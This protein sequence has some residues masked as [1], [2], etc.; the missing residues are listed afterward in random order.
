VNKPATSYVPSYQ[1]SYQSSYNSN[2]QSGIINQNQNSEP[3]VS[4]PASGKNPFGLNV[5]LEFTNSFT[6]KAMNEPFRT[7]VATIR[8]RARNF[9]NSLMNYI[10]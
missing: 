1:P 4:K 3:V 10:K 2:N 7:N 6:M 5:S 9:R 8:Q